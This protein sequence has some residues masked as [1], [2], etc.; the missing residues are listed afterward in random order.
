MSMA[1]NQNVFV[2]AEEVSNVNRKYSMA[3]SVTAVPRTPRNRSRFNHGTS[4]LGI[5]P[6]IRLSD[7]KMR[8]NIKVV[9][10]DVQ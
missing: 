8:S 6:S 2:N 7:I 1:Q 10:A 3:T 9:L 5:G 4:P